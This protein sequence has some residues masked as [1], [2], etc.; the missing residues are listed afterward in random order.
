M[1]IT[2]TIIMLGFAIVLFG[3]LLLATRGGLG[4]MPGDIFVERGNFRIIVPL[5]ASAI[6][7]LALTIILNIVI[8]FWD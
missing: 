7:S 8:R 6:V 4:R 1:D 3:V 2:W 5:V